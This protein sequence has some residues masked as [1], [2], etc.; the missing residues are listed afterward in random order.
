MAE[1]MNVHEVAAYLRLKER[2]V[3]DL[4][5]ARL[6][7]CSRVTGKWVFS[8]V[9]VDLWILQNT[10]YKFSL[11]HPFTVPKVIA[12]SHDPLL[13]WAVREAGGELALLF[14]GSLDG[15]SRMA[16]REALACGLHILDADKRRYNV[17]L[18]AQTLA[19]MQVVALEWAWREQGLI[20]AAGNPLLIATLD[21]LLAKGVRLIDRQPEAGSHLLLVHL[22]AERNLPL[23]SL[24]VDLPPAR[25][26][27]EVALA[28]LEGKADAGIGIAAVARQ[29]RLGFVPLHRERYDLVVGRRDY[30]E[31]SFQEL[32]NFARSQRFKVR[33]AE[34]G[35]Y[36]ISG[37]GR[38]VYNAP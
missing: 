8:K 15:L 14:N 18:I 1:L 32:L 17:D 6:I 36:D 11:S 3:Y 19:S 31:P 13:E 33:A 35:G 26:E 20:V 4:V 5:A 23:A 21:D 28:I 10:E 2:K 16:A 22:M 24:K 34:L 37:L 38:I 27:T 12:G 29:F 30:F 7:P 9:L 25:N